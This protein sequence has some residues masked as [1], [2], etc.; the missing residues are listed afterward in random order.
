MLEVK[1]ELIK[2]FQLKNE[3]K[4]LLIN[5]QWIFLGKKKIKISKENK[6]EL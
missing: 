2:N 6:N 1:K 5:E 3:S 4:L